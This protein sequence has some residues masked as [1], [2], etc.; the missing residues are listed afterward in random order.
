[1]KRSRAT[2]I[3]ACC[4]PMILGARLALADVVVLSA[5]RDNT[6][7]ESSTGNLSNG[8]GMYFTAGRTGQAGGSV[9]RGL[10]AFDVTGIPSNSQITNVVLTLHLS[11]SSTTDPHDIRLHRV[12]A[13]W[14]EGTSDAGSGE[15]AGAPA[16]PG[17]AT[18]IHSIY[19]SQPWTNPGGDFIAAPSATA[20]ASGIGFVTW[21]STVAMVADV[22]GWVDT[23]G[24]AHGWVLVGNESEPRTSKRFD[25]HENDMVSLRPSLAVTFDRPTAVEAG[26]WSRVKSLY[27]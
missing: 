21:G 22:Q 7:I 18:W 23:P 27:K 2:W 1:M 12:L 20:S 8:A 25:S 26:G 14:G 4:G 16:T 24:T 9:R 11:R 3:A 15:S 5:S 17:D 6:I 13:A 19:D 10:V